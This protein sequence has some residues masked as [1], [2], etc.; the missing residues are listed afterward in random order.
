MYVPVPPVE[1]KTNH[2]IGQ[3]LDLIARDIFPRDL[4]GHNANPRHFS[5]QTPE[6]PWKS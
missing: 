1:P 5:R 6:S 2:A 4:F 3:S